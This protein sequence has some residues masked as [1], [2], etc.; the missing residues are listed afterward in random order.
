MK[1]HL[2]SSQLSGF[3]ISARTAGSTCSRQNVSGF[4]G[5]V[6]V[7]FLIFTCFAGSSFWASVIIILR[8]SFYGGKIQK[9]IHISMDSY[10][11]FS[12]TLLS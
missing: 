5:G 11:S 9:K 12:E 6:M 8:R 7:W 4:T 3:H 1:S 10:G 2:T